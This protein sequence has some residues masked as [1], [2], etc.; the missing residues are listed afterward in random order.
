MNDF[1]SSEEHEPVTWLNGYPLYAAHFVVLVFVVSMLAT[2]LLPYVGGAAVLTW[3]PFESTRV[4]RGEVWRIFTYGFV[5]HASLWFVVDMFMLAAFGREIEKAFGRTKFFQLYA[6]LYLLSPL[7]FTLIG[8]RQPM[9]L[10]GEIGSFALFIAFAALYPNAVML[11]NMLAKWVA[12][13]LVAIYTLMALDAH[14]GIRLISLLVTVTFALGFVRYQQGRITLPS[15]RMPSRGPTL[16]VL[17]DPKPAQG[18]GRSS[19][20]SPA[21]QESM[22]EIDALLDKI[23]HSG[24][25]SLTPKERA[26]LEKAREDLKRR[27]SDRS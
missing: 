25:A 13:I 14:D 27:G 18:T 26:Q 19:G 6:G 9:Y 20:R 17:P 7:L 24:M 12:V 10:Q 15:F 11:F 16:R 22:V 1:R 3:L 5:N 4:L 8:L 23:A 2:T 21:K